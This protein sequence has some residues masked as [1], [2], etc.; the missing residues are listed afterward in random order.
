MQEEMV[1]TPLQT[2]VRNF[3]HNPI[4]VVGLLGFLAILLTVLIGDK[5]FVYDDFYRQ[6]IV[7][8]IGPGYGYLDYPNEIEG[9]VKDIQS[10]ATFSAALT[11]DGKI[12]MW[13][14][15]LE[16]SLTPPEDIQKKLDKDTITHMAVGDK[17]IAVLN[18]KNEF[19]GWGNN[20]FD[21][22]KLPVVNKDKMLKEGIVKLK[23]GDQYTAAMT[24]ANNLYVW[25][26]T[27]GNNLHRIPKRLAGKVAD[28]TVSSTNIVVI[29]T[30]GTIDVFGARGGQIYEDI[31]EK[32]QDGS[33]KI[34]DVAM[35][36][37][38]GAALDDQ[39]VVHTW[40]ANMENTLDVPDFGGEKV[41]GVYGGREYFVA[42]TESGKVYTWG[43]NNYREVSNSPEGEGY[44]EVYA[45][46]F[47]NYAV[48]EDGS[49]DTWGSNGFILGTDELGRDM[50]IRII[51]GGKL[52]LSI[53]FIAV[54][55]QVVIGVIV[56]LI[57]GYYGGVIDN[58]LMRFAEIVASFPFYPLVITIGAMLPPDT[59]QKTRLVMIMVILG[60]LGWTGIARLIRGQI[61]AEREKD[62]V[63]AAKALGIREVGIMK[64]HILPNVVSIVIVQAT[65][66]YAGNLLTEAG[67]SFLGFG[68]K[69]PYAS[70]GN[71]LTNAQQTEVIQFFWWRWVF[72]AMG[73]FLTALSV[74]LVGDAMR[75]AIDPKAN[76]R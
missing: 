46:Y 6:P 20:S 15:D 76:E 60:I 63:L 54:L 44:T 14:K 74:N 43:L 75:D 32:L 42:R 2:I 25:G 47:Q 12:K 21:Q 59:P 5:Y 11:N 1:T 58:I 57:S 70:W 72:P 64:R 19:Y 36:L 27:M 22:L 13:G 16:G 37:Y 24:K 51:K 56:G 66:G 35:T 30:D 48:K 4:G 17:F 33:L 31:P 65:L 38:S 18:D 61:L 53:S 10:G 50:W 71:M 55:I 73:V 41:L 23:G 34:V 29:T 3:F 8:N 40:G 62:Y 69:P 45:D 28:F 7:K 68:V 26:S 39:G 67:L 52:T 49:I 9:N